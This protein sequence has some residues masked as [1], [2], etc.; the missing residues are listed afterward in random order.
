MS[1]TQFTISTDGEISEI[2]DMPNGTGTPERNLLM[3]VLERAILDYVGNDDKEVTS[4]AQW[5]FEELDRPSFD[6]FT[7]PWICQELD[8]DFRRIA[9]TIQ[10][11]PKRGA[12]RIAPWYLTKS[13]ATGNWF[14][15][16]EKDLP[17]LLNARNNGA[18]WWK[19]AGLFF[20]VFKT[21]LCPCKRG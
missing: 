9:E 21:Y 6:K 1:S 11:M 20:N 12:S 8:L 18:C 16:V 10:A 2:F 19:S 13:Y 17:H 5:L 4:A 3:A 7:F 14:G 15:Y